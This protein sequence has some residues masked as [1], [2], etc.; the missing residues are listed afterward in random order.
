MKL[1][2]LILETPKPFSSDKT[3]NE[4]KYVYNIMDLIHVIKSDILPQIQNVTP[5]T[6]DFKRRLY[7]KILTDWFSA[8]FSD[9]KGNVR[10]VL[11]YKKSG[12]FERILKIPLFMQKNSNT[13]FS[14]SEGFWALHDLIPSTLYQLNRPDIAESYKQV[15]LEMA[16]HVAEM[17]DRYSDDTN[18]QTVNSVDKLPQPGT[19]GVVYNVLYTTSSDLANSRYF[20]YDDVVITD[21]NIKLPS[22]YK[23]VSATP[24]DKSKKIVNV[25][26]YEDLPARGNPDSVYIT[27][28]GEEYV[29]KLVK[30]KKTFRPA[31]EN[32]ISAYKD[33]IINVGSFDG[34][35]YTGQDGVLYAVNKTNKQGGDFN[36]LFKWD[37]Q[38]QSYI[39]ASDEDITKIQEE[40]V[41]DDFIEKIKDPLYFDKIKQTNIT[42]NSQSIVALNTAKKENETLLPALKDELN[43][44]FYNSQYNKSSIKMSMFSQVNQLSDINQQKLLN[45]LLTSPTPTSKYN[46]LLT[47]LKSTE[48]IISA[49]DVSYNTLYNNIYKQFAE[50]TAAKYPFAEKKFN[51]FLK[52]LRNGEYISSYGDIDKLLNKLNSFEFAQRSLLLDINVDELPSIILK[53][54]QDVLESRQPT[55]QIPENPLYAK[56][57]VLLLSKFEKSE[58]SVLDNFLRSS[59]KES[60]SNVARIRFLNK[61]LTLPAEKRTKIMDIIQ[62]SPETVVQLITSGKL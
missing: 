48:T 5:Q 10:T 62:K 61:L 50:D 52:L 26:S 20:V 18:F 12:T 31:T 60:L 36:Q 13:P 14:R 24:S 33:N 27:K 15:I 4:E 53:K 3:K 49:K 58:R 42:L 59:D 16:R 11:E 19:P 22:T 34:I 21:P 39:V 17:Y 47:F 32:E 2:D 6:Y 41:Y 29:Y 43:K 1:K 30:I 38:K 54:L 44:L 37:A 25:N 56:N 8:N 45:S 9:L 51:I 28:D 23:F 55:Q 46:T 57:P 7:K 35:P 40:G